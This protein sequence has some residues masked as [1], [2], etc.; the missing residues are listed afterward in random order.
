MPRNQNSAEEDPWPGAGPTVPIS[1]LHSSHAVC[2]FATSQPKKKWGWVWDGTSLSKL[3]FFKS[4]WRPLVGLDWVSSPLLGSHTALGLGSELRWGPLSH[5]HM[6]VAGGGASVVR[7]RGVGCW[8]GKVDKRKLRGE[9]SSLQ[10]HAFGS[11]RIWPTGSI[12]QGHLCH[13]TRAC[14]VPDPYIGEHLTD[15]EYGIRGE[16][17]SVHLNSYFPAFGST[18]LPT[19]YSLF[20]GFQMFLNYFLKT[21]I[22]TNLFISKACWFIMNSENSFLIYFLCLGFFC[23]VSG[24]ESNLCDQL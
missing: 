5:S 22:K 20:K 19:L 17:F 24:I 11:G 2:F 12:S 7:G 16:N 21:T 6:P 13:V 3:W 10:G 23:P 4:F 1:T 9:S 8:E 15:F 18:P 14:P